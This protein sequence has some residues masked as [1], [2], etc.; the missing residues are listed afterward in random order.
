MRHLYDNLVN[1]FVKAKS[2]LRVRMQKEEKKP[3][4][5]FTKPFITIS[6]EP[7]SGGKP[8]AKLV[9]KQLGFR[10]YDK[11]LLE[12]LSQSV[13]QRKE[14]LEKINERGRSVVE[15]LVHGFFNPDYVSDVRYIKHLGQ[16]VLAAAMQGEVVILGRG[17]N[18][19]TPFNKALHV[20][21]SAPYRVRVD[22]AVKYEKISREEAVQI[23]K[24]V[25][26]RRKEYIRQYFGRNISNPNYYDLVINTANI[27]IE[28]TA[29]HVVLALKN[30]FPE[31]AKKRKKT[32]EKLIL[33]F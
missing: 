19:I 32:F 28:D 29:E 27:S 31:Y 23:I 8:V 9:A 18:F 10:F 21:I 15:D 5:R 3:E 12:D 14:L 6:R 2:L 16:V 7:G 30:K 1:R 11:Q 22:R 20:R 33:T 25:D 13:R 24:E 17:A 4:D 26:E